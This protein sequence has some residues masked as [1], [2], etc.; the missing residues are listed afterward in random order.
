M[1]ADRLYLLLQTQV[2]HCCCRFGQKHLPLETFL[3]LYLR[4]TE[5]SWGQQTG[6]GLPLC[7]AWPRQN[8]D[9]CH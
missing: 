7:T 2:L 5:L 8:I 3:L 1:N 9:Q 6:A 4:L